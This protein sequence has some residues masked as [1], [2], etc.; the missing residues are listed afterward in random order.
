M[1]DFVGAFV[2]PHFPQAPAEV[3]R[4]GPGSQIATL[5]A[6]VRAQVDAVAPDVLVMFDTDHFATWFYDKM[7]TFSV[8]V[9]D[10]TMG[11]GTDE[12]PGL[13]SYEVPVRADLGRHVLRSGIRSSF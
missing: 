6:A 8:G 1:A 4:D 2:T 9:A 5:F 13:P 7:P 12:W 11:P 3:A 10:H